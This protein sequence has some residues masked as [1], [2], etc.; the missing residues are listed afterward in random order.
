MTL[1]TSGEHDVTVHLRE[2][3]TRLD[4]LELVLVQPLLATTHHINPV[5]NP[6][7]FSQ[8]PSAVSITAPLSQ[9]EDGDPEFSDD[10]ASEFADATAAHLI[11]SALPSPDH[12]QKAVAQGDLNNDGWDD[13]VVV[14]RAAPDQPSAHRNVLLLNVKGVLTEHTETYAP[15]F[16]LQPT[17]ARDVI[18]ADFDDDGWNDVIIAAEHLPIFLSQSRP[19]RQRRME[20]TAASSLPLAPPRRLRHCVLCTGLR[21][22]Q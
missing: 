20:R 5:A 16:V 15:G 7:Q 21:G 13:L 10:E 11:L 19:R 22:P 1:P 14:R 17:D 9:P 2:D 18:I 12:A 8:T 3:G 4:Q 6:R